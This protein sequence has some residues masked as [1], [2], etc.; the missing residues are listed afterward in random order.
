MYGLEGSTKNEHDLA[1]KL[2]DEKS[3][4]GYNS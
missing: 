3:N 1:P 4:A 2:N